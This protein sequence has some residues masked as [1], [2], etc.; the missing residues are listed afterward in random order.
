MVN[1]IISSLPHITKLQESA[2]GGEGGNRRE[3]YNIMNLMKVVNKTKE[4]A[5]T[6]VAD[7]KQMKRDTS[8]KAQCGNLSTQYC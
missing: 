2:G 6:Q 5:I 1:I 3:D 8:H 4:H 7:S